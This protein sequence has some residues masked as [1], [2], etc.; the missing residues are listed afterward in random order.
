MP[1]AIR[2]VL[3]R[4]KAYDQVHF[5]LNR[6]TLGPA[7]AAVLDTVAEVMRA[8]PELSAAL[9]GHTDPRGGARYNMLLGLRRATAVRR[10][11]EHAGVDSSRL[12]VESRGKQDRVGEGQGARVCALDRRVMIQYRVPEGIEFPTVA[13][14]R[15]LQLEEEKRR[16]KP[17]R[18]G[19]LAGPALVTRPRNAGRDRGAIAAPRAALGSRDTSS[20]RTSPG[21]GAPGSAALDR[22]PRTS[23]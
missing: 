9:V 5:G 3:Y 1:E 6:W 2:T 22:A 19:A 16:A 20:A 18:R 12:S 15:D 23:P 13:Q 10:Y 21:A 4:L 14:I 7:S 11:L 17:R 8:L